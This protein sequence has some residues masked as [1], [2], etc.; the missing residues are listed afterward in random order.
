MKK[1][2]YTIAC[3]ISLSIGVSSCDD[4]LSVDKYFSDM[5]TLDSAF[6]KRKYVEGF[7]ADAWSNMYS[8]VSDIASPNDG[9]GTDGGNWNY[10]SDDLIMGNWGSGDRCREYQNCEYTSNNGREDRWGRA[11]QTIRKASTFIHNVDR[12]QD[13]TL[14]EKQDAKAQARF[15]RA[16]AYWVLIRQYG[17]MPLIPDEGLDVSASYEDLS[18]PRSKY[19]DISEYVANEFALAAQNLPLMRTANNIGRPTRGAALSARAKVLLYAA[20]PLYNGNKELF[21]LK[22]QDGT[23][24]IN[25]EY[26]EKKW[27]KAAVAALEVIKLDQYKLLTIEFNEKTS[28][29]PPTHSEYSTKNFPDGWADIDPYESYRQ[30][31]NGEISPSKNPELIFT[32]TNDGNRSINQLIFDAMPKSLGGDNTIATTLKQVN[33]YAMNDGRTIG[34]AE[35]AGDYTTIGFTSG[36]NEY[37]YVREN[38]S[39]MFVNREPRFY[40]SVSFPGSFWECT[41]AASSEFKNKQIF[42]YKNSGDNGKNLNRKEHY[43]RTGIGLKKYVHPEDSFKEGGY[44][45]AKYEPAIRYAD[46]LLWYAEA[47]NEL[48]QSYDIADYTGNNL[49]TVNRN[50]EELKS[51]IKPIRMRAGIPDLKDNI[52][53]DRDQFRVAV[54]QE[55]RIEMF[56]EA[57][58]YWDL[59]R[60]K[61]APT[62]E[63]G[64]IQGFNIDMN[65]NDQQR[66]L[67]YKPTVVTSIPK[68]FSRKM[69]LWPIPSQ[70]EMKRNIYLVQNPDWK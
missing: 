59:R 14:S 37:P 7:L 27:A 15:V 32:R 61:D 50:T 5:L 57:S 41:S 16:Y 40:A 45:V 70:S 4:Y 65:D 26:D 1:L 22:N 29:A 17:P 43:L 11:Y 69:Y 33:A 44:R 39:L 28:I 38:V 55:R 62:E 20:S 23:Q 34:E 47:L 10:A 60:W 12:C 54:K 2:I 24:L 35:S 21:D 66:Q 13:M 25:Q 19:D 42:Y 52:Y 51:A 58:R 49:I 56:A 8:C 64:P 53:S 18:I 67:F 30:M 46:V 9:G 31:F 68:S 3:C 48:T 63:I 36:P 6:T